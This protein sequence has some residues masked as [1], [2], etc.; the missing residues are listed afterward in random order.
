MEAFL[1][2][3]NIVA[4]QGDSDAFPPALGKGPSSTAIWRVQRDGTIEVIWRDESQAN[5]QC[6]DRYI[7][8][9]KCLA[10]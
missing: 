7:L 2:Y 1:S 9:W 6:T 3:M 10:D 5:R 8:G 4:S